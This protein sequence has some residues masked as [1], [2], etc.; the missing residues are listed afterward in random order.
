[1]PP[2]DAG[3]RGEICAIVTNNTDEDIAVIDQ[4]KIGQIVIQPVVYAD[5]VEELPQERGSDG[6]GSTGE[7]YGDSEDKAEA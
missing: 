4:A 1:M 7:W 3:Y 5:F 6:F 2:I